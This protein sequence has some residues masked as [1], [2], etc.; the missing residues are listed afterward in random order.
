MKKLRCGSSWRE[1]TR[2]AKRSCVSCQTVSAIIA[3]CAGMGS[4]RRAY[5]DERPT[6]PGGL[7][8]VGV[9]GRRHCMS[10]ARGMMAGV[11]GVGGK[12]T[13]DVEKILGI[14]I[15]CKGSERSS[16]SSRS[17]RV[18]ARSVDERLMGK[19]E[20]C[21]RSFLSPRASERGKKRG[22]RSDTPDAL[23]LTRSRRRNGASGLFPCI[24]P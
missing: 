19:V 23:G 6:P 22:G 4:R 7:H 3:A 12:D 9:G 11:K 5:L 16:W 24:S 10:V 15:L 21:E 14:M 17:E 20:R 8:Q 1:T 13:M 2:V 18:V